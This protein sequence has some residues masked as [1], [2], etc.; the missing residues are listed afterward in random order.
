M[1]NLIFFVFPTIYSSSY[2]IC[3]KHN[4]G[5][6]ICSHLAT[7]YDT[8]LEQNLLHIVERYSVVEIKYVTQQVEQG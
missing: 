6:T 4:S 8:P 5:P 7:L 1:V 3:I 2:Y